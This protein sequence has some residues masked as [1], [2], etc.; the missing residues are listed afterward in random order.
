LIVHVIHYKLNFFNLN[1]IGYDVQLF[2][3]KDAIAIDFIIE[4]YVYKN[5]NREAIVEAEKG[6]F[7]LDLGGCWGDT[8]LYFASKVGDDGKVF[9]FEFIPNNVEIFNKNIHLNSSLKDR[10]KLIQNP[11]SDASNQIMYY[12]D[13]GPS[14]VISLNPI[15]NENDCVKTI[16]IDDFVKNN[17][18]EKVDFIK[19]DIEGAEQMALNGAIKTIKK[20]KPKLAIAIYHSMDDFSRIPNWI[21]DLG[22]DYKLYLGHYTIHSEETIIFAV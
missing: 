6:D 9:S 1:P 12:V 19:M 3:T 16:S 17:Q 10:I 14:S 18:I 21:N 22:M 4:Q 2:F 7:V 5:E 13:K 15:L 11:V 8:A 20:F